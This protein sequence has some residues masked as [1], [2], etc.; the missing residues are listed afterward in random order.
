MISADKADY[1][2]IFQKSID[3]IQSLGYQNIKA[4]FKEFER[5]KSYLKKGSDVSVT[6]D[7]VAEKGGQ[8]H[9]FELGLKSQEPKLLKSKWMFLETLSKFKSYKFN[10]ITTRGHVKF[11]DTLIHDLGFSPNQLIKL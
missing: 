8:M 9:V 11:T 5:P 7:I 6:P 10:I 1:E 2:G 4:D 3:H